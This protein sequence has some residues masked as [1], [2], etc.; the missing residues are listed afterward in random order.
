MM[1]CNNK[2]LRDIIKNN[3]TI[4]RCQRCEASGGVTIKKKFALVILLSFFKICW[5]YY[6]GPSFEL[7]I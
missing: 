2:Y 5:K 4:Q 7:I 1:I 3:I 6:L